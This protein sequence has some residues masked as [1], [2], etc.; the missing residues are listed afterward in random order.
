MDALERLWTQQSMEPINADPADIQRRSRDLQRRV[1]RRNA[2]EYVAAA[3]VVGVFGWAAFMSVPWSIRGAFIEIALSAVWIVVVLRLRGTHSAPPSDLTTSEYLEHHRRQL[4]RQ[5]RLVRTAPLWY[6]APFA[7]GFL[8]LTIAIV[9]AH[10]PA[11]FAPPLW[12]AVAV[13]LGTL[14]VVVWVNRRAHAKL[15]RELH[16][17]SG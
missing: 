6:V 8:W 12:I 17:L 2:F 11:V 7:V 1:R 13:Q 3:F 15:E 16:R 4:E 9:V 14:A 10:P 5:A